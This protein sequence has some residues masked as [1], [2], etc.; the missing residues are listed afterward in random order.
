M[1]YVVQLNAGH[2]YICETTRESQRGLRIPRQFDRA[3]DTRAAAEAA[4]QAAISAV[5]SEA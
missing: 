2:W 3:Y 4:R 5:K 1:F